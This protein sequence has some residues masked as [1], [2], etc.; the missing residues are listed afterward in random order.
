[1]TNTTTVNCLTITHFECLPE[2]CNN[3]DDVLA[4]KNRVEKLLTGVPNVYILDVT[5]TCGEFFIHQP[6]DIVSPGLVKK[7]TLFI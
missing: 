5:Y 4:E 7:K 6:C 3:D 1:M 2:E